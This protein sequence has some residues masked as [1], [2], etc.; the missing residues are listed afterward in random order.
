[1]FFFERRIIDEREIQYTR[2]LKGTSGLCKE[3]FVLFSFLNVTV[4][5][6]ELDSIS[7]RSIIQYFSGTGTEPLPLP[8]TSD[9]GKI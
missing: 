3:E 1:M 8:L 7:V 2:P 4:K 6:L 9:I 5:F